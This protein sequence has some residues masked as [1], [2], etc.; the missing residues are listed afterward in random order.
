M[1]RDENTIK[2]ASLEQI[3]TMLTFCIRGKR[4][5][6]GHCREMIEKG[7]IRQLLERLIE[8]KSNQMK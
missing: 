1:I 6:D 8:I 3:Q 5:S 7:Y 4:F 2:N